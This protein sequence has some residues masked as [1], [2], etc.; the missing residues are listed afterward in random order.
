MK[1]QALASAVLATVALAT[2]HSAHAFSACQHLEAQMLATVKSITPT[3]E[4]KCRVTFAWE[5]RW[6]YNPSYICPLDID[7]VS[8]FGVETSYCDVKVGDELSGVA[9]R[10][11]EG[12]PDD[13]W[14]Y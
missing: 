12:T 11:V 4:G 6:I 9:L 3:T 10:P 2:S 7:E 13:I 5:Q 14:L 1:L 8:S